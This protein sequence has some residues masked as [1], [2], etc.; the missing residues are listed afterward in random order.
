MPEYFL[1]AKQGYA[2]GKTWKNK[3]GDGIYWQVPV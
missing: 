2:I 1:K 3:N